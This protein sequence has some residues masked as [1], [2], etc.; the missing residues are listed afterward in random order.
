MALNNKM[1]RSLILLLS[2][3]AFRIQAQNPGSDPTL[4]KEPVESKTPMG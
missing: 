3:M 1:A 2:K 4:P